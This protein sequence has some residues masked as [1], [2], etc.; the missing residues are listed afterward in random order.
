MCC[1][2]AASTRLYSLAGLGWDYLKERSNSF[3]TAE[4]HIRYLRELH[5]GDPVRVTFQ[6]L[7]FDSK[8]LHFFQQLFHA[9]EGWVSATCR[10]P[11]AAYRH[12]AR[13]RSRPSRPT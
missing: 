9:T 13:R 7:D 12:D 4:V 3:F 5:D 6:L 1:S 11:V 8:R 2:I 10:K